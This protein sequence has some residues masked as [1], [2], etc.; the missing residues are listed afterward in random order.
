MVPEKTLEKALADSS[1]Q[2]AIFIQIEDSTPMFTYTENE[3]EQKKKDSNSWQ[4]N[5]RPSENAPPGNFISSA[6]N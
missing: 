1:C 5:Q 4:L 6:Q 3:E 2:C